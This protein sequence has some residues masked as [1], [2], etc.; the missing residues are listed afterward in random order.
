MDNKKNQPSWIKFI[1]NLNQKEKGSKDPPK[2]N[3]RENSRT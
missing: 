1:I 3:E 2:P